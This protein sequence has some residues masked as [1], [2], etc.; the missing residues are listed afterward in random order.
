[1]KV[2][3]E[4]TRHHVYQAPRIYTI[5]FYS[6]LSAWT[7]ASV[8]LLGLKY[9]QSGKA[10]LAQLLMIAFIFAVTWYF[11][12]GIFYRIRIEE[13]GDIELTS[14]RRKL[15]TH[16]QRMELVEGP[17]FPV[18]FVRFRLEREKAY[19][20]CMAK[21]EGLHRVLSLIRAKNPNIQFKSL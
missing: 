6:F 13:N 2:S 10:D 9:G 11:S 8:L 1:M 3:P 21:N 17:L 7:I 18:G 5:L 19:L 15:R 16:P 12:L 20:F 14:F 4:S